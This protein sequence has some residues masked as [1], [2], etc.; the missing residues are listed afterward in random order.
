MSSFENNFD[1]PLMLGRGAM[2]PYFKRPISFWS[3]QEIIVDGNNWKILHY[4]G[5]GTEPFHTSPFKWAITRPTFTNEHFSKPTPNPPNCHFGAFNGV[6]IIF[7]NRCGR[8]I[9]VAVCF[10]FLSN[11]LRLLII[12]HGWSSSPCI[13]SQY[14]I[15]LVSQSRSLQWATE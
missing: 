8:N 13:C 6:N 15:H 7:S 10:G 9:G 1:I 5:D 14:S 2:P 3:N 12:T 4:N 11:S